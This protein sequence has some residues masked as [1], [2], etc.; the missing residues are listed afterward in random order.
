MQYLWFY[1]NLLRTGAGE[2][3]PEPPGPAGGAAIPPPANM[4]SNDE[5]GSAGD[6]E[7]GESEEPGG[8]YGGPGGCGGAEDGGDEYGSA[9]PEFKAPPPPPPPSDMAPPAPKPSITDLI[10]N[11]SKVVMCKVSWD[12]TAKIWQKLAVW[13]ASGVDSYP[14]GGRPPG[15][16][17]ESR[18]QK[19]SKVGKK[20]CWGTGAR[21]EGGVWDQVR[22]DRLGTLFDASFLTKFIFFFA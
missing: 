14:H 11:P 10:R 1:Y 19:L 15:S 12:Q 7:G 16:G 18:K 9:E 17:S 8:E 2:E 6:N 22:R 20:K 5:Y 21:G 3:G 4:Y 13:R